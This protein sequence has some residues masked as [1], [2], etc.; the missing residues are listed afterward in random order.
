MGT[1]FRLRNNEGRLNKNV[2]IL[3]SISHSYY[4]DYWILLSDSI[5]IKNIKINS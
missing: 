2:N 3:F 1:E 5:V 4:V